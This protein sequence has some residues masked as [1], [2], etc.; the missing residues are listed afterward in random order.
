M[1]CLCTAVCG[2]IVHLDKYSVGKPM[3]VYRFDWQADSALDVSID[4]DFAGRVITRTSM[5]GGCALRGRHLLKHWL[6]TQ[7]AT[8]LS[9]GEAELGGIFKGTS[10]GTGVQS[11]GQ[12]LGM[13]GDL[14]ICTD[15]PAATAA[16]LH[17]YLEKKNAEDMCTRH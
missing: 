7:Q 14:R 15:S 3:F 9:P 17:K 12:D 11:I 6:C 8:T 16:T 13:D 5:S 1:S 10:E 2:T 4:I